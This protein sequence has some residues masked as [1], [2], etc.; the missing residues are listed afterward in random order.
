MDHT[1]M[2]RNVS[3]TF[4]LSIE[5]LPGVLCDSVTVAYLLLRVSDILEDNDDYDAH[6]KAEHLR[7][8]ADVLEQN[9][10]LDDLVA[11]LGALDPADPEAFVALNA[12]RVV[13]KLQE[14]PQPLQEFIVGR[15][16]KTTR[17]MA[18]WQDHGPFIADELEMDDYMHEVAG[19]VGYLL[20]DIF[21]WYSPRIRERYTEL[22]PLA[23]E[24]GLALQTVNVIR[25]M[26]KDY[27]RGWV[28]VPVTYYEH[29][30]LTRDQLFEAEHQDPAMEVVRM[31]SDKASR[32]L[33]HGMQYIQAFPRRQHPIRLACMW[34]LF[35]AVRTLAIS[36]NNGSV[37]RDEAKMGRDQVRKIVRDS[38]LFGWSNRWI[39]RY[40]RELSFADRA[41]RSVPIG[42][43]AVP[44]T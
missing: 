4:A 13:A 41:P 23:R 3:R 42:R 40:Y 33:H 1:H 32:H 14:L 39:E 29:V 5:R 9:A 36:R 25:G 27:E 22:M 7:L 28:F 26:R 30:G 10:S 38:T 8:W 15:V 24:Y 12:D 17:G 34:P 21:A 6:V 18:R 31:L 2:L 20:T 43:L 19:R 35:F 44:A 11:A 37:L 16:C